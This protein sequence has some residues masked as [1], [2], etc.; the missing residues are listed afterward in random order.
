M[1]GVWLAPA[2]LGLH[3]LGKAFLQ[4]AGP[5]QEE[6]QTT[7]AK[8]RELSGDFLASCF[9]ASI[10]VLKQA[11]QLA[12]V[13]HRSWPYKYGSARAGSSAMV[14]LVRVFQLGKLLGFLK[15]RLSY[16]VPFGSNPEAAS[17]MAASA[18]CYPL[19]VDFWLH[20]RARWAYHQMHLPCL[21]LQGISSSAS[22]AEGVASWQLCMAPVVVALTQ[23]RWCHRHHQRC[24]PAERQDVAIGIRS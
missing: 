17:R 20:T 19:G 18:F 6:L 13:E 14:L 16:G 21:A 4:L 12:A 24:S 22:L 1:A 11:W 10:R 7:A 5:L 2:Q 8:V 15:T 3:L 23:L 9:T